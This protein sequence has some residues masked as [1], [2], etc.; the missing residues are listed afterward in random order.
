MTEPHPLIT[1]AASGDRRSAL[2]ELRDLLAR[3]I[4]STRDAR[5]TAALSRQ[6]VICLEQ[7][8]TIDAPADRWTPLDE[9][10]RRRA[11]RK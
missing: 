3:R 7:I 10:R 5:A 11:G 6:L 9:L 4:A 1:A 2:V 8:D